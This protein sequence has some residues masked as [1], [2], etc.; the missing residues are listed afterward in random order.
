MCNVF[1]LA[2]LRALLKSYEELP[3]SQPKTKGPAPDG[4]A[5]S[6]EEEELPIEQT[7]LEKRNADR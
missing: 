5:F 7:R 1:F 3:T 2:Q 4:D 6:Q